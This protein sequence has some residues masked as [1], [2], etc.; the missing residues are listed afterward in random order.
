MSVFLMGC[1]D[2][3]KDKWV[4]V[5]KCGN[6]H[7]D[8]ALAKIQKELKVKKIGKVLGAIS[9]SFLLVCVS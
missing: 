6:G 5:A 1:F 4:T 2:P 8:N 3:S 9:M 7:D